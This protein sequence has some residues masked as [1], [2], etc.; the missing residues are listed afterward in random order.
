MAAQ[1]MQLGLRRQM[2]KIIDQ[3]AHGWQYLNTEL[4]N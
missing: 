1:A 4:D 2:E 3:I